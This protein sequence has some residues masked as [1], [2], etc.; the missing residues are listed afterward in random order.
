MYNVCASI[1][2]GKNGQF[3]LTLSHL[4]LHKRLV[5]G[6]ESPSPLPTTMKVDG[7]LIEVGESNVKE[8]NDVRKEE[9]KKVSDDQEY[10][11]EVNEPS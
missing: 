8:V 4:F 10:C 7:D 11:T 3:A 6:S 1:F 9:E 5:R 2:K